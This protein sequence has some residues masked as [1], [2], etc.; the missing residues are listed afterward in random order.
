LAKTKKVKIGLP[1]GMALKVDYIDDECKTLYKKIHLVDMPVFLAD[2]ITP[3]QD[4]YGNQA[5]ERVLI[6]HWICIVE[7][8]NSWQ[9]LASKSCRPNTLPVCANKIHTVQVP[10]YYG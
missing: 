1:D 5:F 3:V 6:N 10:H 7:L 8:P 9:N 2:G 4:E